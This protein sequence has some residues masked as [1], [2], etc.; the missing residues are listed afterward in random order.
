MKPSPPRNAT[1]R[2]VRMTTR[3]PSKQ[4]VYRVGWPETGDLLTGSPGTNVF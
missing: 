4:F 3:S 1:V 2:N